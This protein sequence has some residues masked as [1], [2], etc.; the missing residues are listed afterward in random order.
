MHFVSV[1]LKWMG[2]LVLFAT[3]KKAGNFADGT[4]RE[5][6]NDVMYNKYSYINTS[7]SK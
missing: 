1:D 4:C 5:Y 7:V 6:R 2:D 3:H